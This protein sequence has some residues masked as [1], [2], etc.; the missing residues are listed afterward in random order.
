VNWALLRPWRRARVFVRFGVPLPAPVL[1][2][3]APSPGDTSLA[4][5]SY[6]L[7]TTRL[8]EAVERM[9]HEI[10]D[11]RADDPIHH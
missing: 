1:A 9:W 2:T 8:H 4:E 7:T 11:D 6:A 5:P 10:H 3:T